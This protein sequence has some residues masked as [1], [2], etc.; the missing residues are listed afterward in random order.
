MPLGHGRVVTARFSESCLSA[1]EQMR[2][3]ELLALGLER[4]DRRRRPVDFSREQ[5]V[6]HDAIEGG[7][8]CSR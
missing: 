1:T 4:R 6:H 7:S 5:S 3:I 2:F 8:R